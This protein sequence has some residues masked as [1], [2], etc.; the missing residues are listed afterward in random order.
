MNC[1]LVASSCARTEAT[2]N[3]NR[4]IHT[5]LEGDCLCRTPLYGPAT[6]TAL[7]ETE[8]PQ[9]GLLTTS[10]NEK[11]RKMLIIL[12]KLQG[13]RESVMRTSAS[14]SETSKN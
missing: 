4:P 10:K 14:T 12:L 5:L 1:G 2:A 11:I 13:L 7:D 9:K 6:R 3:I 8:A